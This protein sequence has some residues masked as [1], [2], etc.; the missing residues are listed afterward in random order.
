MKLQIRIGT[1]TRQV[2]IQRTDQNQFTIGGEEENAQIE[3]TEVAPNTYSILI[4]GH[5]F[6]AIVVPARE[7]V[8]V[9]CGGHEF[10]AT[11][12]DPRAWQRERS[13]RFE[14]EGQQRIAAPMPGKVIRIL[15]S[16]GQTVGANQG[17]VVVEAMKMQNEIRA[18]RA[19][20]VDRVFIR[21]GQAVAA[22][23]ALV[24]LK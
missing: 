11:V 22:G 12:S 24:T 14:T 16:A 23:E 13:A 1:L 8:R 4:N 17:L 3:A 21:D 6:E 15:V 18:P 10:H 2:E 19:G 7:G 9:H 20:T 5:A